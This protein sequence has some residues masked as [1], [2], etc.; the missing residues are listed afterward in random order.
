MNNA[1]T[2]PTQLFDVTS[3]EVQ[4]L[5]QHGKAVK[6]RKPIYW[7]KSQEFECPITQENRYGIDVYQKNGA[8]IHLTIRE[9]DFNGQLLNVLDTFAHDGQPQKSYNL[10]KT[11]VCGYGSYQYVG[12]V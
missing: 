8:K 2:T 9:R 7:S 6:T 11:V 1:L 12:A 4:T 10:L 5:L 3:K